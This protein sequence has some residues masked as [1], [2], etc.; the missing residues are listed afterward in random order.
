M[1]KRQKRYEDSLRRFFL[2]GVVFLIFKN[3]ENEDV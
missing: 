1:K 2:L 3:R